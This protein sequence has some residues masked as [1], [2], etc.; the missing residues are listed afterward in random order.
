[1]RIF[2]SSPSDL[3]DLE[4]GGL[5]KFVL[6][7]PFD[8]VVSD[9]MYER[10]F[11]NFEGDDWIS[12]GL[13]IEVL[14]PHELLLV[15]K[16]KKQNPRL[17]NLEIFAFVLAKKHHSGILT[18]NRALHILAQEEK[19]NSYHFSWLIEQMVNEQV[20]TVDLLY[21]ALVAMSKKV[22]CCLSKE[23]INKWVHQLL[24]NNQ[25]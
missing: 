22:S 25:I 20:I 24:H 15:K 18:T 21:K 5:L 4:Q 23:D 7:L 11:K 13:C 10:E 14:E 16:Y 17:S 12:Q 3:I 9:F 6:K 2:L 8:L 19:I 1:M